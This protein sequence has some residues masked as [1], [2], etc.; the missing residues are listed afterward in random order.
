MAADKHLDAEWKRI[1]KKTFTRWCNE[2][3]KANLLKIDELTKDLSDGVK[4]IVLLEL[5]SQKKLGRYN[6]KPRVHAQKMEN[7]QLCLDFITKK[8]RIRLVNIGKFIGCVCMF[9]DN[10]M[11][12]LQHNSLSFSPHIH[13]HTHWSPGSG[14][15]VGGNLKL[16]LGLIWTLILHYQISIGF[17]LE[18]QSKDGP[19]PKQALLNWLNVCEANYILK[20]IC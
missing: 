16:I 3:L 12:G 20:P 5:L 14:D 18:D 7:V 8:E 10:W 19:T 2:H 17:G 4:L 1:Q 13:T 11:E 9:N 15:I 6:K